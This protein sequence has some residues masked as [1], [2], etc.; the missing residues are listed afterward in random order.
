MN[1]QGAVKQSKEA[2]AESLWVTHR[3]WVV[4][5]QPPGQQIEQVQSGTQSITQFCRTYG[6]DGQNERCCRCR[7]LRWADPTCSTLLEHSFAL[8]TAECLHT[9]RPCRRSQRCA[10]RLEGLLHS[11][12]RTSLSGRSR[13]LPH[14]PTNVPLCHTECS[15][16]G[17]S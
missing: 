9:T 1:V 17:V 3:R 7:A 14:P 4:F 6:L 16:P 10:C 8:C 15:C 12:S 2:H 11:L 5:L 13:L